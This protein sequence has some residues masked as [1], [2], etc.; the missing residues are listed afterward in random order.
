MADP[1]WMPVDYLIIESLQKFHHYYGDDF[2]VECPTG[3]GHYLTIDGVAEEIAGRLGRLFLKDQN[4]ERPVLRYHDKLAKDPHFRDYVLFHEY[5]HGD[6][7]RGVEAYPHQTG[8]TGLV[9]KLLQARKVPE[10]AWIN[11]RR[12]VFGIGIPVSGQEPGTSGGLRGTDR[13]RLAG[14][15]SRAARAQRPGD[16]SRPAMPPLHPRSAQYMRAPKKPISYQVEPKCKVVKVL[17]S[18]NG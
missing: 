12:R 16:H 10:K 1:F 9:A 8:W 3:S 17:K 18:L 7:G 5:F 13:T 14:R 2:K 6:T 11:F 4:G 15:C